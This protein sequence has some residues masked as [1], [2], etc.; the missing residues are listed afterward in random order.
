MDAAGS[1]SC[2]QLQRGRSRASYRFQHTWRVPASPEQTYAALCRLGDYPLWWPEVKAVEPFDGAPRAG[3]RVRCR[4]VLPYELS[5]IVHDPEADPHRGTL[6]ARIAGDFE[7]F[8]RWTVTGTTHASRVVFD[9]ELVPA[10]PF[11][12]GVSRFLRPALRANHLLMMRHGEAGLSAHL[13]R[14]SAG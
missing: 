2:I 13:R 9:E 14:L 8:S 10:T 3:V 11:L 1:H 7:G 12:A 4:S 5:L 6:G